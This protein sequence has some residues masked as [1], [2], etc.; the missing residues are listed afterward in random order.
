M[1]TNISLEDLGYKASIEELRKANQLEDFEI[2]RVIAEHKERYLVKTATCDFEAEVT[3][4]LRFSAQGREDFPAVG[5]WVALINYDTNLAFIHSILPRQSVLARQA[6]GK[7]GEK[8]LIATNIDFAFLVQAVDRDF[9][10]NRLE[11]YLTI[12]H[13]SNVSPIIVLTKTDLI[14]PPRLQE[15]EGSVK[16]RIK[17]SPILAISNE[18]MAGYDSLTGILEKGKTYCLLGSSG[19]GKS[20]LMNKLSGRPL[21]KTSSISTSTHK[22]RHVTTHRELI[23]LP[24]GGI[25][26]D[27]PGMREIGIT[28]AAQALEATFDEIVHLAQQC[29]FGDCTHTSEKGCAV[30]EAVKQGKLDEQAYENFLKME[31]EQAHF[32][33]SVSEKRKKDK[34]FGKMI[35]NV[36]TD[37]QKLSAKHHEPTK[38]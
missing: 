3:G 8:Q 32:D 1:T 28:D 6:V 11:R 38:K 20:T 29:K 13:S 12:C 4:N 9:N 25:L 23:I 24:G 14:A 35:K 18:T 21:M 5:D 17:N 19:V 26:I 2:G 16:R 34:A 36:K 33:L 7:F 27:N 15:I 22:G 37:M 30:T 10:I 31:R